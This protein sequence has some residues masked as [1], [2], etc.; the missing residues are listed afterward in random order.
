MG[1]HDAVW[2]GKMDGRAES[3]DDDCIIALLVACT[4]IGMF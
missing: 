4:D 1:R 3:R 2:R